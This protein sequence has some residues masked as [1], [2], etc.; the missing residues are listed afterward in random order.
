[1]DDPEASIV[2][3][4]GSCNDKARYAAVSSKSGLACRWL[5]SLIVLRIFWL[6]SETSCWN[7][8]KVENVAMVCFQTLFVH[9]ANFQV[10]VCR[11][12]KS[13]VVPSQV[14]THLKQSHGLLT[15]RT[16]DQIIKQV[17]QLEHVAHRHED[18]QYPI[19]E[20]EAIPELG[21]TLEG[22]FQCKEC[23]VLRESKK[24]MERHCREEHGWA[25]TKS[26]GGR[27]S[28]RSQPARNQPFTEGHCCQRF[29]KF[30]QWTKLFKVLP[31][32]Q[33]AHSGD[34]EAQSEERAEK[35]ADEV[36]SGLKNRL[37]EMHHHRK[38]NVSNVRSEMD[39]WLEHTGWAHHLTGFGKEELRASLNAAPKPE[40]SERGIQSVVE[41]EMAIE[42]ACRATGRVIKKAM[43]ISSPRAIP[44]SALHYVNRKETGAANNE[45]PF[46][47]KHE[48]S[49]LKKYFRVWVSL[50][51][52]LWRSQTWEKKPNYRLTDGQVW[53][54][55]VVQRLA[56]RDTITLD[57]RVRRSCDDELQ[58]SIVLFWASMLDQELLDDEFQSGFLSAVAVLGLDAED[59]G[60]VSVF[61]F[62]PKLA[63]IVTVCKA[64]V[65]FMA[66]RQ[67][68]DDIDRLVEDG[69]CEK[70]AK[71]EAVS[72]VEGVQAIVPRLL[73]LHKHGALERNTFQRSPRMTTRAFRVRNC[74][75]FGT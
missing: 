16:R 11:D 53:R 56:R 36:A 30:R 20:Q 8:N 43:D 38:V 14:K 35:L 27:G 54:L 10:I 9:Y 66:Y 19:F 26:R 32:T 34:Q 2:V 7:L 41:E 57:K 71:R 72:V 3:Q 74:C 52:Y 45:T 39:P 50:L 61:N 64:L 75:S 13:A 68:Q 1:M 48:A 6:S 23:G 18:V 28:F 51:R 60:W 24:G 49:T 29:F 63:A 65:V 73:C 46:Y 55:E 40:A 47:N 4:T 58:W 25:S 12:C 33:Q 15:T 62:T 22:C 37:L 21:P 67:R 70:E 44:R 31:T 59:A 42:R 17:N 5:K 69:M